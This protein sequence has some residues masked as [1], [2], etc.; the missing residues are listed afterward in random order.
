MKATRF[1]MLV[2][3]VALVPSRALG[4]A[5]ALDPGFGAG[6]KV[7]TQFGPQE[8]RANAGLLQPDGRI[9]VA[10]GS[11][12][13]P[14]FV[15]G[16][17]RYTAN[18]SLDPSFGTGGIVTTAFPGGTSEIMSI[19]LQPDGKIVAL[20][21]TYT[22]DYDIA[23]VR[24]NA[25]GSLDTT[26]GTAGVVISP[27]GPGRGFPRRVLLQPDHKIVVTGEDDSASGAFAA[28]RFEANGAVDTSFG[29][30]G[31]V[32][33]LVGSPN[34]PF[35]A[36]IQ[37]SGRI[38]LAGAVGFHFTLV[39]YDTNGQLDPTFG[40]GGIATGTPTPGSYVY[41]IDQQPDGKLVVS[42]T[43][44][45]ANY[46]FS[47]M[48]FDANGAVDVGFG[49][50]GV[51]HTAASAGDDFPYAILAQSNGRIVAGGE[52]GSGFLKNFTLAGY[53]PGGVLDPPFGTGGIVSTAF[54]FSR[55][56][57]NK[58]LEQPDGKVVAI[59]ASF[60]FSPAIHGFAVA[61]YFGGVCGNGTLEPDEQCDDGNLANGDCCSSTCQFEAAGGACADE[62]NACTS[63]TCD[64]AGT[65]QHDAITCDLCQTCDPSLGCH[66]GP[67]TSCLGPG[68]LGKSSFQLKDR[69]IPTSDVEKWQWRSGTVANGDFGDPLTEDFALCIFHGPSSALWRKQLIPAGGTCGARPC[70]KTTGTPAF[71][72]K[73]VDKGA[74]PDGVTGVVLRSHVPGHAQV[75]LKGRGPALALPGLGTLGLPVRVQLQR[76]GGACWESTHTTA[77]V[78]TPEVFQAKTP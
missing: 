55:A 63:D 12:T 62:G 41:D 15:F 44:F 40:V 65:C 68:A 78:S 54:N 61:R 2:G 69:A 32:H 8:D 17:V 31:E 6:G 23:L 35:G 36:L 56:V 20:G 77:R 70:W 67:R 37:P 72:A 73:Y 64:G 11:N 74:T 3:F 26:F 7:V 75:K 49:T 47:V 18:G 76:A 25:N 60:G 66:D 1:A 57:V 45:F 52:A 46:D 33:T 42:G 50:G 43:S 34:I 10:G 4:A 13:G 28:A 38:V 58:L 24:Y 48:R 14:N 22:T 29:T 51:V 27:I 30:G 21:Y 71:I 59:G 5:G 16:L 39:G 19:V 9:V 53:T